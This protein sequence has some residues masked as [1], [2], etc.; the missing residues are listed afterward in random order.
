MRASPPVASIDQLSTGPE[1]AVQGGHIL[2]QIAHEVTPMATSI[3]RACLHVEPAAVQAT[4]ADP[5]GV[6]AVRD[7]TVAGASLASAMNA[8]S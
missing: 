3:D 4:D 5:N 1:A 2:T 7:Q 6:I 8:P